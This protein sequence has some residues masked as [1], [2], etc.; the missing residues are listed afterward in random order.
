MKIK[1]QAD[2]KNQVIISIAELS[3]RFICMQ[4]II[5]IR[6]IQIAIQEFSKNLHLIIACLRSHLKVNHI[7][8]KAKLILFK[9]ASRAEQSF[10][11]I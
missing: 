5:M 10:N 3:I 9:T 7:F 11:M 1:I 6:G 4:K 8:E 2:T